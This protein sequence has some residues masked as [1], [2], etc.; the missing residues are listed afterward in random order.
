MGLVDQYVHR[1][2]RNK[3]RLAIRKITLH[4]EE[5][6]M[7]IIFIKYMILQ[8]NKKEQFLKEK[9][10]DTLNGKLKWI[11]V[12][13][14]TDKLRHTPTEISNDSLC[15]IRHRWKFG[16]NNKICK[17]KPGVTTCNKFLVCLCMT[18][19]DLFHNQNFK[20]LNQLSREVRKYDK[21]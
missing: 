18:C 13:G 3:W 12:Y 11:F 20:I 9:T 17:L 1:S 16:R 2:N 21:L 8:K 14:G 7:Q 19:F 5:G 15:V 10:L 4:T 6:L